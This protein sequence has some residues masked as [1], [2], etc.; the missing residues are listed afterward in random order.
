VNIVVA[1]GTGFLGRH[2]SRLL[3]AGGHDVTVLVRNPEEV[4]RIPELA[5]AKAVGGDV[6]DSTSLVDK[7]AGAE[8][9]VAAAQFPNHPVEVPRK[10]LTYDRFD[11]QGVENLVAEARRSGVT[12]FFYISGAGADPASDKTW[13]RAKGRAEE[14]VRG[15]G[16]Q[17]CILRPSWAYGPED[18]ALN[19]FALFARLSPVIP[20]PGADVQRIQPVH[21]EDIAL[22]VQRAFERDE[23]WGRVFEIGGPEV[24]TMDEVIRTMCEVMGKRRVILPIPTALAKLGTAPLMLLPKP[25]MTPQGIDF[26]VQD[27]VVDNSETEQVLDVQPVP[28][29]EGLFRYMGRASRQGPVT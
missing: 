22:A 28:L 23:A 4:T 29:M 13:Y 20:K 9:V 16:L 12:R 8:A 7:L 25:P 11:R 24:M 5:G 17:W 14:A 1:G 3:I 26:A 19:R 6:T 10:G 18:R 2:I 27:G 21:V 15:S